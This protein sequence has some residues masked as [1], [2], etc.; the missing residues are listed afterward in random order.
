[1]IQ[2]CR[3][4]FGLLKTYLR[5]EWRQVALLSLVLFSSIGTQLWAAT[6]STPVS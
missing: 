1:M 4:L 2:A 5:P 6:D 3:Q